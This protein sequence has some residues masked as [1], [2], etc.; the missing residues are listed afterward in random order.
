MAFTVKLIKSHVGD[1][2]S[3]IKTYLDAQTITTL[4]SIDSLQYGQLIYTI[5]VFE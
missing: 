3:D 5:I 1:V 2:E 4:H